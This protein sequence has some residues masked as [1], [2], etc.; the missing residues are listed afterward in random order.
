[1]SATFASPLEPGEADSPA[2]LDLEAAQRARLLGEQV[3]PQSFKRQAHL[4][5]NQK[6]LAHS[7]HT[8]CNEVLT[9]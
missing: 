7:M 9:E 6:L 3:R 8:V 1:M 2:I 4:L 5:P